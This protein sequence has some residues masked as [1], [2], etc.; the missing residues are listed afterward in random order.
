MRNHLLQVEYRSNFNQAYVPVH[1]RLYQSMRRL[2][3][4]PNER[5]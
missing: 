2:T 3:V 1:V 4:A 5:T